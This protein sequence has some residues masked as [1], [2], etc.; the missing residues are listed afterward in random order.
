MYITDQDII[1]WTINTNAP[2]TDAEI[3]KELIDED[4]KSVEK[5]EMEA[6]YNYYRARNDII[7]VDFR[8]YKDQYGHIKTQD[9][10]ANNHL[11]HCFHRLLVIQKVSYLLGN[12]IVIEHKNDKIGE[13]VKDILGKQFNDRLITLA[14]GASNKGREWMHVYMD[15]KGEFRFMIVDAR[16]IIPVYDT[17]LENNLVQVLR[18]YPM[19]Y[20]QGGIKYKGFQVQWWDANRV[21]IYDQNEDKSYSL[22]NEKSHFSVLDTEDNSKTPTGWGAPPFIELM[23]NDTLLSDLAPV[24]ALIDAYDRGESVMNNNL[25]DIQEAVIIAMGVGEKAEDLRDKL[26]QFKVIVTPTADEFSKIDKLTIDIPFEARDRT[27]KNIEENIFTFGMG[28]NPKTDKFGKNASGVALKWLYL[29]LDL[30]ANMLERKFDDF[31]YRLM[32]FVNEFQRYNNKETFKVDDFTFTFNK[33]M[34]SNEAEIV[35]ILVDSD[36]LISD[37]TRLANHPMIDDPAAEVEKLE[38]QRKKEFD[39]YRTRLNNEEEDANA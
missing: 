36:G 20:D 16:Q 21:R 9:N 34:I 10:K 19:Q 25:E 2:K 28:I 1:N 6:G 35:K 5:T 17:S 29:L 26:R 38:A 31:L 23:N 37:E 11:V 18:Y 39:T 33:S 12:P 30:K 32:W 24:K 27:S 15:V 7:D 13:M 14:T 4:R 3:V 8:A 22:T